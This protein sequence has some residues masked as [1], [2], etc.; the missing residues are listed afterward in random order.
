MLAD[1]CVLYDVRF[2]VCLEKIAPARSPMRIIPL[3][4]FKNIWPRRLFS[5]LTPGKPLFPVYIAMDRK[6]ALVEQS[7][8]RDQI[9]VYSDGSRINGGVGA[10]A[11]LYRAGSKSVTA[12]L[13]KHL[14]RATQYTAYDAEVLGMI[15]A[16]ELLLRESSA[17]RASIRLDCIEALRAT[18]ASRAQDGLGLYLVDVLRERV[19][20]VKQKHQGLKLVGRWV[21]GHEGVLGNVVSDQEAKKAARG[22]SSPAEELPG[23]IRGLLPLR[24][25]DHPLTPLLPKDYAQATQ[26]AASQARISTKIS[27]QCASN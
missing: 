7:A 27:R 15:L 3:I 1:H 6:A 23:S 10:A 14:G 24:K 20:V 12:T 25:S 4:P 9:E 26:L 5:S 8:I 17:R 19:G 16:L 11:V 21:P 22:D 18:Q 2:R 13:R